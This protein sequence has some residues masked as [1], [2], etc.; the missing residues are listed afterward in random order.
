M[1]VKLSDLLRYVIYKSGEN[2]VSIHE[3]MDALKNLVEL[4]RLKEDE[5]KNISIDESGLARSAFIEPMILIPLVENC[6]KHW[7]AAINPNAFIKVTVSNDEKKFQFSTENSFSSEG[8]N[9]T[10]TDGGVGLENINKR[11]NLVYGN[12]AQLSTDSPGKI[13]KTFFTITWPEK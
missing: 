9:K 2:K 12:S 5:V 1:I 13:Y 4:F 8:L 11:L 6:F 3:E 10:K 7:D